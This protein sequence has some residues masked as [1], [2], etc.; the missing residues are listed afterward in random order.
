[1]GT[2]QNRSAG[3]DSTLAGMQLS[4]RTEQGLSATTVSNRD[5]KE[6]PILP[7]G[8]SKGTVLLRDVSP[9]R[10]SNQGLPSR[11]TADDIEVS[12]DQR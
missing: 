9:V 2:G 5:S 1:M 3:Q 6:G 7:I 11:A 12:R 8:L 10:R 4:G